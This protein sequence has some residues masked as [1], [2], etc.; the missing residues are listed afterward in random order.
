MQHEFQLTTR[1]VTQSCSRASLSRLGRQSLDIY[2][3]ISLNLQ[4]WATSQDHSTIRTREGEVQ[5][6][7]FIT[8]L[9]HPEP[10]F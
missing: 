3:R 10:G 7:L 1:Q 5:F 6:E 4:T 2:L 9:G 8:A